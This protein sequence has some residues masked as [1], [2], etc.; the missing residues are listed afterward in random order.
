MTTDTSTRTA[1]RM[2]RA[3]KVYG[4]GT[5]A[6]TALDAVDV[7]F[8]AGRFT[9]IMGP[10]GSGKSTLLHCIAGLDDL[11]S[12]SAYIGDTELGTLSD[13]AL[14]IL[15][16]ERVGFIFQA[17]NLIPTLDAAE[18]IL[19]PLSI[20]GKVLRRVLREEELAKQKGEE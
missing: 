2:E 4:E 13:R 3:T 20:A 14:T 15:R 8:E 19:L 11:T 12:G 18:N 9:A 17:Y 6:V 16:R 10:S 5:A 7:A 1:A